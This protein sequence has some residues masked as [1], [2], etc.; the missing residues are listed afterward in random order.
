MFSVIIPVYNRRDLVSRAIRSVLEQQGPDREIIVVDDASTDNTPGVVAD[1][2]DPRINLK[3]LWVNRE[4]NPR[5]T[6][7]AEAKGELIAIQNSDDIWAENKLQQQVDYLAEHPDCG[8]VF[9]AVQLIDENGEDINQN[10]FAVRSIPR[11][12]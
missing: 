3:R 2:K 1:I 8:A 9:T 5:N 12:Q 10:W 6:G 4:Q 7:L 11:H